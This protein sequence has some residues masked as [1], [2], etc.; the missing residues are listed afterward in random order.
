MLPSAAAF[1]VS[2]SLRLPGLGLLVLPALP[3]PTWL[4]SAGLHTALALQ[5]HRPGQPPLSL[6]ATIE[7]LTPADGPPTRALLLEADLGDSLPLH[8]WL[9]KESVSH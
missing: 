5:L 1:V 7:E 4:A 6:T 3:A 9:V 2:R 8:A